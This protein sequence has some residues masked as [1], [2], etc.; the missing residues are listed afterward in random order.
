MTYSKN[1]RV[2][3]DQTLFGPLPNAMSLPAIYPVYNEDGTYNEDGP[4]ANPV[5]I[6]NETVNEAYTNRTNGNVFL[7]YSFLD[8]FSFSTKW[9]ADLYNLREHEYDPITVRQGAKY[10]GL[11]IEGTNYF[12]N[13]VSN[14][15]LQYIK[16]VKEKHNLEAL[17]GF[18]FENYARRDTYIEA[19]DFPN[20]NLQYIESAGT[21]RAA[22]ASSLNS[23]LTSFFGQFKYNYQYKYIFTLT[24]R[25][26]GSS[27][28]GDNNKYGFF[29]AGSFAWRIS[30]EPFM[31]NAGKID[32]LKFRISTGLTGNDGIPD[33]A[34]LGLYSGGF[35]YDGQSGIAPVQLANPDLK[36]ESTLST[37]LGIDLAMFNN[38]I[39][40]KGDVYYNQT[41]DLLFSRPLPPSTGYTYIYENVGNLE[42]KGV[43]LEL[44]TENLV[45]D[46][47]WN[48]SFVF[49]ANR[50]LVTKLYFDQPITDQGRGGN[51]VMENE[52]AGI[53]YNYRCLGVD[54]T[55]GDLVYDDINNDGLINAED[56]TK[57][58]DPNPDFTMGLTNTFN[59]KNFDL[60]VFL[61]FIIGNDVFNGT[62]I[63]LE[64]GTGEDNQTT[65]MLRRW[66]QPGDVTD[67][68][69]VGDSYKSSR[70]IE[71]GS[72]CRIK[73][74]TLGY[75]FPKEMISKI[76]MKTLRLFVIGQN[77]GTFTSYSGMDPEVNYY[78]NDNII[79]GTDFFTY[80][81]ARSILFGLNVG[82]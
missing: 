69:R 22:S 54:P 19:I 39:I 32:E 74:V 68:P 80:P 72:F 8:G 1:K 37:G 67:M 15:V 78:G 70:F 23:A 35:D 20:E 16:T 18:S 47:K 46:F 36:W 56:Y 7:D 6:C 2:E 42:N 10:N 48:T 59:W 5:A 30:E 27:K 24:G 77:L 21:I 31:E 12:S 52:P 81:Q 13:L 65:D 58:G 62:M 66:K 33:F 79:M 53:F 51:W 40:F 49:A 26:D 57:I 4:Y 76:K 45:N 82:F 14:N 43:E 60:S 73:N 17:A 44:T 25:A 3:G 64:S 41:R 55:T 50:N 63:Y 75:N 71:N 38:R 9:S 11:G 28:F 34:F 29:P 61:H